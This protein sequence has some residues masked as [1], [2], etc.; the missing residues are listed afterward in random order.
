[1]A[2]C[3]DGFR[4]YADHMDTGEFAAGLDRL[5]DRAGQDA[6]AIMC[7]ESVWWRCHRRLTSDALVLLRGRTVGHLFHDGRVVE[8]RPS[9]EARIDDQ[10]WRLVYDV[11]VLLS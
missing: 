4:G 9:P 7:A 3:N 10:R 5:V 2:L 1:V 11:G 6:V 8:H